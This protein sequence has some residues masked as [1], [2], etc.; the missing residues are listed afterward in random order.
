MRPA[1]QKELV[2]RSS[3]AR[4]QTIFDR[5]FGKP[6]GVEILV[7][8]WN[9]ELITNL[10]QTVWRA[11]NSLHEEILQHI[12]WV[13]DFDSLER[14]ISQALALEIQKQLDA[15]L[16]CSV[17]HGSFEHETREKAP[18]QPPAYDIAFIWNKDIRLMWPLEA[19]VLKTDA[20]GYLNDYIKT[21]HE[22]FLGFKYAPFTTG[23]AM[24]GYLKSGNVATVLNNIQTR[25]GCP[26]RPYPPFAAEC[27][28]TSDHIRLVPRGKDYPAPFRCH[29]MIFELADSELRSPDT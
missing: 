18:A 17:Q 12:P 23:A 3:L 28:R 16:P 1:K 6:P 5:H 15:S 13:E 8:T 25:L 20:A 22:R 2:W 10:L 26:L 14:T 4:G 24:L 29:H 19:K 11:Y 7:N 27:H 9:D 21:F